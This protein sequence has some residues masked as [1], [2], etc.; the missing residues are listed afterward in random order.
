MLTQS[1]AFT[2]LGFNTLVIDFMGSGGSEGKQTTIGFYE[3]E[4][5]KNAL[6]YIRKQGEKNII[7]YGTSMGS[8]AIMLSL[9]HISEPTRPY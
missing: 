1:E 8:A 2:N 4:Q 7:L 6:N 9:I 3:A 5:V